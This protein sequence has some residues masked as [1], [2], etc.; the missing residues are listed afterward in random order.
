MATVMERTAHSVNRMACSLCIISIYFLVVSHVGFEG[1]TLVLIPLV[2]G[3]CWL[4][5][6]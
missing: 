4:S 2:P 1:W 3:H 5:G 6:E